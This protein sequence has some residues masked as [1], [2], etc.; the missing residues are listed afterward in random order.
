MDAS[1]VGFLAL[2]LLGE[3]AERIAPHVIEPGADRRKSLG[4]DVID[5][6]GAACGIAHE[7]GCLEH[8]QMLRHGWARHRDPAGELTHRAR[9]RTQPLEKLPARGIC[10]RREGCRS[11]RS[12]ATHAAC[13][14]RSA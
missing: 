12:L 11:A 14:R 5:T 3:T 13:R 7:A 4:I 2:G 8:R 10:E 6:S 1:L 9:P